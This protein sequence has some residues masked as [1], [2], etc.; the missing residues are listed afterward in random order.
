[1][2]KYTYLVF[3]AGTTVAGMNWSGRI[4]SKQGGVQTAIP[5]DA[6]LDDTATLANLNALPKQAFDRYTVVFSDQDIQQSEF[7]HWTWTPATYVFTKLGTTALNN[8][9]TFL[10]SS[11]QMWMDRYAKIAQLKQDILTGTDYSVL[12][13]QHKKLLLGDTYRTLTETDWDTL[14]VGDASYIG[15]HNLP[16]GLW[17]WIRETFAP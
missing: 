3:N 5:H 9:K 15:D 14:G 1:M 8:I 2:M 6:A 13:R 10:E 12:T 16:V 11:K 4:Y 17:D 7:L